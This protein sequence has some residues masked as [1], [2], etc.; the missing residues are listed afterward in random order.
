[1][2][3]KTRRAYLL[4]VVLL[5]VIAAGV[6][7]TEKEISRSELRWQAGFLPGNPRRGGELFYDRGCAL[8]HSIG[9]VGGE[10]ASDLGRVS[11]AAS[12]LEEIAGM[13]WN[14]APEMWEKIDSR[15]YPS[16]TLTPRDFVDLMA[17]LF[18]AGYLEEEGDSGRGEAVL[19]RKG[20]RECHA[21][22]EDERKIGPDLARW[23]SSVN[24]ILWAQL[25]WNHTPK[26]EKAMQE[27]GVSWPQFSPEEVTDLMAFL[28][29]AA[30]APRKMAPLPGDPWAGKA[31]FREH[32]QG[33]HQVEGNGGEVGPDLGESPTVRTLSGLAASLWNHSPAMSERMEEL[34]LARPTFTEQEMADL[35]TYL[36]AIR[37]FA[38]PGER[39]A[40][41]KVYAR[42]CG[43]C[44]GEA[45]EG[46]TGGPDL[47]SI[48]VRSS[49]TFMASTLWNHGPKMYEEMKA[50]GVSWPLFQEN[51][52][53]DLIEYLRDLSPA[54]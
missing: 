5:G 43:E 24:P 33:C 45:G 31:L 42:S 46:G 10:E 48:G 44:H 36:F 27:E 22:G 52:M 14:H 39:N 4:G 49:A 9:G 51:E 18:A 28:R 26:M 7:L 50:K 6:L 37:Y 54:R 2:N 47:R 15:G 8:C 17:F 40:G 53:R 35:V 29:E 20:C 38:S 1:M 13:M 23:S 41:K 30:A 12:D 32:C 34:G 21:T 25:L 3:T 16:P 11:A 19:R